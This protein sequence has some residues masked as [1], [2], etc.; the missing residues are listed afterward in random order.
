MVFLGDLQTPTATATTMDAS[1]QIVVDGN[2]RIG[3]TAGSRLRNISWNTVSVSGVNQD[4]VTI[5]TV[6]LSPAMPDTTYIVF[7]T[8]TIVN[9]F[10]FSTIV[11]NKTTTSFDLRV[12]KRGATGTGTVSVEWIIIDF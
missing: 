12:R 6:T 7:A 9:N 2:F 3:G 4:T 10:L 1:T 8:P 5:F 11:D